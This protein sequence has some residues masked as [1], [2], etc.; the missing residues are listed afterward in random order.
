MIRGTM[1][2]TP[3]I[4]SLSLCF[5]V[6]CSKINADNYDKLMSGMDYTEAVDLLGDPDDCSGGF[7]IKTCTWGNETKNIT[8]NFAGNKVVTFSG[9]G[10]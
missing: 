9:E 4:A 2:L 7:G 10:L 1:R 8:I 3:I 5:I 6:A